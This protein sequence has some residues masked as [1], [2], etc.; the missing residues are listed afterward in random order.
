MPERAPLLEKVITHVQ[1]D[2]DPWYQG[3]IPL[4]KTLVRK[5]RSGLRKLCIWNCK[6]QADPAGVRSQTS[7]FTNSYRLKSVLI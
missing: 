6:L 3:H 1:G 5:L 4:S 2:S 7:C